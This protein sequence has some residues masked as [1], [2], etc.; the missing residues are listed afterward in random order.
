MIDIF[1]MSTALLIL[2]LAMLGVTFFTW[3]A[4]RK[5]FHVSIVADLIFFFVFIK[6]GFYYF[7]PTLMRIGS[8][9]RFER[10]DGVAIVDL[11]T[12]YS[13]ELISWVFWA[14]A[15]L[16]V[17][18]VVSGKRKRIKIDELVHLKEWETKT[19]LVLLAI[20]FIVIQIS[21]LIKIEIGLFLE[22]FKSLFFY[23]GLAAG[24][25]LMVLSL[26]YYGKALFIL[27]VSSSLFAILSLPTRGAIVYLLFFSFFLVWFVLRDKKYKIII[28]SVLCVLTI[29]YFVLGGLFFGSI[30]ID[31]TGSMH[32]DAGI[33]AEKKGART[34]F[35]EI[36]WR[37]GAATRLGTSFINLYD[38]GEAAG[39]N[40]IKNSLMGFLPRSINPDKP[41]PST[42]YGDDIYSQGMYLI[43]REI[44]G[45]DTFSMIEFP[46][47]AHSYWEFGIIGVLV[48]SAISGLYVALC[49]HSFCKLGLV[50]LPL[51]VAVFKPWGYVDPKIWVSDIAMQIYQIILP[52]ILLVFII[53]FIYFGFYL[54]RKS[55]I[56][57]NKTKKVKDRDVGVELP[58]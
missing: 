56:Y 5:I 27:G 6:I 25:F 10:E 3:R 55:S 53:R 30:F 34:N 48:L 54:F 7:L 51:M 37:F 8:S 57:S 15:L 43:Y 21:A 32:V 38:R 13:I 40:P 36:E 20:G 18:S 47:G 22:I 52:L 41:H 46:T 17:F 58:L 9:Y 26:K 31:E 44:Y 29:T 16:A 14:M 35:E 28:S 42:S 50:V 39:I 12:L 49:A 24:P 11:V 23:A 45:Y 33:A 1:F 2:S 19:I 4:A